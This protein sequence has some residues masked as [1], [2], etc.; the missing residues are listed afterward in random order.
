MKALSG[1]QSN[2]DFKDIL[3]DLQDRDPALG[4]DFHRLTTGFYSHQPAPK[5]P[6]DQA[7]RGKQFLPLAR[8]KKQRLASSKSRKQSAPV[9]RKRQSEHQ[10]Y[11]GLLGQQSMEL[12]TKRLANI[13]KLHGYK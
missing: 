11:Q 10:R 6:I 8:A 12:S 4:L 5:R 3:S 13:G 2:S 7:T 1:V 9:L